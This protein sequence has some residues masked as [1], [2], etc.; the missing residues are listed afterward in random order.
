MQRIMCKRLKSPLYNSEE[1]YL[2]N[3]NEEFDEKS[4]EVSFL[5]EK[6]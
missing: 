1:F 3:L 2:V 6:K 5:D 4:S